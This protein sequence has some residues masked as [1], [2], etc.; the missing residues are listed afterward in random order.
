MTN[1]I[2]KILLLILLTLPLIACKGKAEEALPT[3]VPTVE[4]LPTPTPLADRVVLI[5]GDT[6]DAW[7]LEQANSTLQELAAGTG[8]EFE[9]RPE[10]QVNEITSDIKVLV[11]LSHPDN[12]GS[13]SNSALN[14]QF[15]VISDQDWSPAGNVTIIKADVNSQVFMAGYA[16][17]ELSDN[18]R[19]A[20]LLN[21]EE[22][23]P[24]TAFRNGAKYF[25]GLCNALIFPLNTYPMIKELPQS[26]SPAEWIAGFNE[27][28]ANSILFIYVP[29]QAYS[30]DLFSFIAQTNVK[31]I[32]ISSPPAEAQAI[33]AGTFRID[34][35]SP[36]KEVWNDVIAGNGGKTVNASLYLTDTQNGF[37]SPGKQTLIEKVVAEIQA[38][39][40]YALDAMNN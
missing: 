40:I 8:F 24:N 34:G 27:L 10:I 29:P 21:S 18:F 36:M 23:T 12:L 13:L 11:F 6:Q 32:G 30:P 39:R 33:W 14:T 15:L 35:F 28:Y 19:G 16:V 26:S 1:K 37:I 9:T 4:A 5:T 17:E 3:D 25:C 22:S 7:T 2:I 31:V 38:G 20:G